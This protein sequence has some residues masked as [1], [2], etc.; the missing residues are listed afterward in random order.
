M[1][2]Q[3]LLYVPCLKGHHLCS[4]PFIHKG[5]F[6]MVCFLW[7]LT[8]G[9]G[10]SLILIQD[11]KQVKQ[12]LQLESYCKVLYTDGTVGLNISLIVIKV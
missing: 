6:D 1:A 9:S 4:L 5:L 11:W 2:S 8:E 12:T 3:Q 7:F 10:A